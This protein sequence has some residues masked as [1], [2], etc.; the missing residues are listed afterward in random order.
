MPRKYCHVSSHYSLEEEITSITHLLSV[1]IL[2]MFILLTNKETRH[3]I[4]AVFKQWHEAGI[5]HLCWNRSHCDHW[6][7]LNTQKEKWKEE[8]ER[9]HCSLPYGHPHARLSWRCNLQIQSY[10]IFVFHSFS[11]PFFSLSKWYN[12]RIERRYLFLSHQS[13]L[14]VKKNEHE[15]LIYFFTL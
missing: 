1:A 6:S 8:K 14:S 5:W 9:I 13:I 10:L 11:V 15:K 7:V 4:S 3:P 12:K 2:L